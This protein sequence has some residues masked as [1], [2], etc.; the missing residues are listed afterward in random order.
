MKL[1]LFFSG[2]H[3]REL[4][5]EEGRRR[6]R[7]ELLHDLKFK[8]PAA[9]RVRDVSFRDAAGHEWMCHRA[10]H[11]ILRRGYRWNG[12][13]PKRWVPVLGWI[14]TPDTARNLLASCVHDAGYQFSG[15]DG[16]DITRER[17]DMIFLRILQASGFSMARAWHGA[18]RDFGGSRWGG[19][20]DNLQAVDIIDKPQTNQET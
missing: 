12:C 1:P 8:L 19:N 11:R 20:P 9:V 17:E 5:P 16:W 7:W 14:G 3:Y 18:V 4:S 13:S 2:L 15:V 10:G 6:W